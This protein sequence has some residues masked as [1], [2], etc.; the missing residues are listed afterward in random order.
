MT[1]PLVRFN[2]L[3]TSLKE[4]DFRLTPQ[5]V[6]LVRLI[7]ASEGHPSASQLF[8]T[9]KQRFPTMS[10]ATVYK[11]LTLLKE[12]GQVLEIDL[13]DDSRYDGNRPEPHPHLICTKCHAIIDGDL[14][15]S[16]SEIQKIERSTGFRIMRSQVSFFG[17]CPDCKEEGM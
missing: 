9:I 8:D 15:F 16:P 3:M 11:T 14:D 17:L 1:D 6:E 7:A 12:M 4:R 10:Q 13:H 2:E 5:R